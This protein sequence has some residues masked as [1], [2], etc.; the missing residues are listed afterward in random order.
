MIMTKYPEQKL[1]P[2]WIQQGIT[3][4]VADWA[5][6]FGEFLC[7]LVPNAGQMKAG[8]KALTTSQLRRFFG[9]VKRIET[10]FDKYQSD[11]YM[12]RPALAY[13]IGRDTNGTKIKQLGE[14]LNKGLNAIRYGTSMAKSDFSNFV[15]VFESIV[16]YHKFYGG[17]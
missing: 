4:D 2:D 13:A 10:D 17:K 8:K 12:L 7:D 15:K 1:N 9:E 16:A 6:S 5:K 3:P 14:E 11:A